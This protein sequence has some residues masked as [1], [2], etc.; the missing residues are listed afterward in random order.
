MFLIAKLKME[1]LMITRELSVMKLKIEFL[2]I[3]FFKRLNGI[4]FEEVYIN[5]SKRQHL[6]PEFKEVN[7]MKQVPAIMDGRFK[8]FESHA[9]L[10]YLA[11]AFPGVADHWYPADLYKRAKVDSVLDWH[12]SNLRRGAAAYVFSTVFAPA[13]GLPLNQQ[14]AAEAEKVL[15]ASLAKIESVWL[16]KKGRFL[17]GSGQPSIADLSLVCEIMQLENLLFPVSLGS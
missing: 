4:D 12:H 8:L 1:F 2:K 11:C 10:R 6:S 3:S 13:F 15:L 17:L 14:A 16:Q 5:L 9:I 7:P